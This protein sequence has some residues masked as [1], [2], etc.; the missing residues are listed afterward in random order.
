MIGKIHCAEFFSEL[1][2]HCLTKS[3]AWPG[4]KHLFVFNKTFQA[5]VYF[6][7]NWLSLFRRTARLFFVEQVNHRLQAFLKRVILFPLKAFASP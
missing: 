5:V 7:D 1:D 4:G 3:S 2:F 6:S